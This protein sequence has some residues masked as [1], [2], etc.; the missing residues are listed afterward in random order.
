MPRRLI[1]A[2]TFYLIVS[3]VGIDMVFAFP[4]SADKT[5]PQPAEKRAAKGSAPKPQ[6]TPTPPPGQAGPAAPAE[7]SFNDLTKD[8]EVTKGLFTFY[9][10]DDKILM[11]V[12]PD[13]FDKV[14]MLS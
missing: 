13:Q 7:K 14:Y 9:R 8:M 6:Q 5:P 10:K 3:I 1:S 11:E 12:R 2:I 4:N